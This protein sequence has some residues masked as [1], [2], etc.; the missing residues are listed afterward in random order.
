MVALISQSLI[1]AYHATTY[2]VQ[3]PDGMTAFRANQPAPELNALAAEQDVKSWIFITAYNPYS[4]Q[5]SAE[6]N[7]QRQSLLKNLLTLQC[8]K[9]YDG[10]GVGDSGDWPP[11][12]SFFVLDI[13]Q[14]KA[15]TFGK[16][17]DQNAIVYCEVGGVPE[18]LFCQP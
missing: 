10:A 12:P 17:F 16:V 5:L 14:E 7:E 3:L 13:A 1:D 11:E 6:E 15:L 4:Q 8:Y 9:F 18:I 2:Q